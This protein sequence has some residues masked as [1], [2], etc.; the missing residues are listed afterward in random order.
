MDVEGCQLTPEGCQEATV[1]GKRFAKETSRNFLKIISSD[2]G[3]A[4]KTAANIN[5]EIGNIE[6]TTDERLRERAF[7][8]FEGQSREEVDKIIGSSSMGGIDIDDGE[9]A[10]DVQKRALLAIETIVNENAGKNILVVTHGGTICLLLQ[11]FLGIGIECSC[12]FKIRNTSVSVI[13]I[14]PREKEKGETGF[15]MHTVVQSMGDV[16]HLEV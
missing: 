9:S 12:N 13:D 5:A 10:S 7:G 1:L 16:A 2:L 14:W 4:Y 15:N 6:H 8:A 11:K 3:R